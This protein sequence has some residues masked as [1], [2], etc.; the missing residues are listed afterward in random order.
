MCV[1]ECRVVSEGR[2]TA[3]CEV[4]QGRDHSRFSCWL[5]RLVWRPV[6]SEEVLAG[7]EVPGSKK[8]R[9]R[10]Y[11]TLHCHHQNDDYT[12]H[13]MSPPEWWLYLTYTVTTRM[14]TIPDA[15]LSPPKWWLYLTLHCHHTNDDYTWRYTVTTRLMTI[16]RFRRGC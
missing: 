12:Y 9:G 7:T 6:V 8:K 14:M 15:T 5:L 4:N 2:Q 1:M 3:E 10:L 13:Y 11:L 16:G